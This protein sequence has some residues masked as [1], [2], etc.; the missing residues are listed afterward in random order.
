VG[1]R[2]GDWRDVVKLGYA[3]PPY[4]G[5]AD[6]YKDHADYAGEVDMAWLVALTFKVFRCNIDLLGAK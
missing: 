6:L 3:D 2:S 5:C 1:A 4:I